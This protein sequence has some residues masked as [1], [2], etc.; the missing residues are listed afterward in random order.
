M[1]TIGSLLV[2]V[3]V[4]VPSAHASDDILASGTLRDSSGNPVGAGQEVSLLA[5]PKDETQRNSKVGEKLKLNMV[6]RAVTDV[7]GRFALKIADER[8]V[9]LARSGSG[10]VDFT[11]SSTGRDGSSYWYSFDEN[12]AE[13]GAGP[14]PVQK[15]LRAARSAAALDLSPIGSDGKAQRSDRS[16]AATEELML[17]SG[18]NCT[19]MKV[20]TYSPSWV[21]VGASFI[22]GAGYYTEAHF[23]MTASATSSLGIGVS[24]TGTYGSFTRSGERTVSVSSENDYGTI[25]QGHQKIY[26][27]QFVFAKY[28]VRCLTNVT[29]GVWTERYEVRAVS[30]FGGT[31]IYGTSTIPSKNY[32]SEIGAGTTITRTNNNAITWTSGASTSANIGINLTAKTGYSTNTSL[33]YTSLDRRQYCGTHAG[34]GEA[35]PGHI[36]LGDFVF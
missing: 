22:L 27:T 32:C 14:E 3:M 13:T 1:A 24:P 6:G 4:G 31:R 10:K 29:T 18:I 23:K 35:N 2:S 8:A 20:Q 17:K 30:H 5:W 19:S 21:T 11:V 36:M 9:K 33:S 34:P 7:N 16:G 25:K 12:V 26:Q 28:H 15:D